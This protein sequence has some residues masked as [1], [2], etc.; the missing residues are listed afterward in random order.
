MALGGE[1]FAMVQAQRAVEV[2]VPGHDDAPLTIDTSVR[3]KPELGTASTPVT[4]GTPTTGKSMRDSFSAAPVGGEKKKEKQKKRWWQSNKK[5]EEGLKGGLVRVAKLNAPEWPY[6]A[7]GMIGAAASALIYPIYAILFSQMIN[8]FYPELWPSAQ[9]RED[10]IRKWALFFLGMAAY[11]FVANLLRT[12]MFA[13]AGEKLTY[14]LRDRLMAA[15][16]RQDMEFFDK[17]DN[18]SGNLCNVLSKDVPQVHIVFGPTLA[19]YIQNMLTLVAGLLISFIV[20]WKLA[21]ITLALVPFMVF[22]AAINIVVMQGFGDKSA[23]VFGAANHIATETIQSIRIVTAFN[24]QERRVFAYRRTLVETTARAMTRALIAGFFLGFNQLCMFAVF[25]VAFWYGAKL[26]QDDPL[27]VDFKDVMTCTTALIFAGMGVGETSALAKSFGNAGAS[28]KRVFDILDRVPQIDIDSTL[29]QLPSANCGALGL[30]DVNFVYPSRPDQKI[31]KT[32]SLAVPKGKHLALI[33]ATGCGKSTVMQLIQRF[34]DPKSGQVIAGDR[35]IQDLNL[36]DWRAKMAIVSQE[37]VLFDETIRYNIAYGSPE[38]T[39]DQIHE[40]A[41]I[42]SI[43]NDIMAFP[44]GYYTKVGLRGGQLSGG[45][46]QRVAIARAILQKPA[47]LL[48]DEVCMSL[49]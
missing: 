18:E 41:K 1:Y 34:Y 14:R 29:G 12:A 3:T 20:L 49:S 13:I 21:L 39:D 30:K 44:E 47:I 40:A 8:A 37:P 2:D 24:M 6:L 35:S 28:A 46:R 10:D 31:L 25:G 27:N 17:K 38:A 33:G 19:M 42:A 36:H 22:A 23:G 7:L 9:A 5:K 11:A 32:M 43:H 16:L 26:I 15:I 48:L 4:G 45:Q